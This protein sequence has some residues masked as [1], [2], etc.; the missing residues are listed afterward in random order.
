MA[1][2]PALLHH[3]PVQR[4]HAGAHP[5]ARAVAA[6]CIVNEEVLERLPSFTNNMLGFPVSWA[7]LLQRIP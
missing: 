3:D 6:I 7:R 1:V 4:L 5:L 2:T